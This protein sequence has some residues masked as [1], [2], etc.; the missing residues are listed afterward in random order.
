MTK[1]ETETLWQVKR[2]INKQTFVV[3]HEDFRREFMLKQIPDNEDVSK[4]I[5]I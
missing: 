3:Y 2:I 5:E 1:C 4:W